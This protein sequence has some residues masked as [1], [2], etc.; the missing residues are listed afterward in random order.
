MA[1]WET[2]KGKMNSH[3]EKKI[4][5]VERRWS[6]PRPEESF[7]ENE[8]AVTQLAYQEKSVRSILGIR[9]ALSRMETMKK[10]VQ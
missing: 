4:G 1:K 8:N 6:P 3:E 9:C 2:K 7:L 10:V 5:G